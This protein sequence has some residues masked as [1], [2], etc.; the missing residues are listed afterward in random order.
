[1]SSRS[2]DSGDAESFAASILISLIQDIHRKENPMPS[3][4]GDW[5][6]APPTQRNGDPWP[7]DI[8][9]KQAAKP[10]PTAQELEQKRRRSISEATHHLN[11]HDVKDFPT[12]AKYWGLKPES[13]TYDS[14][15]GHNG[16]PDMTTSYYWSIVTFDTEEAL[17]A[18][19]LERVERR[20]TYKI[21]RAE[22]VKT[23]VK[24]VFSVVK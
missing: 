13:Q 4:T 1:M 17:E 20:D 7:E 18:W 3:M 12:T 21:V 2:N 10:A 6:N 8:K 23:E 19:V 5:D 9:P 14:G 11:P 24:A 22:P 16:Q 15:Y